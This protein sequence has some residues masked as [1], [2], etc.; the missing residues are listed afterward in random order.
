MPVVLL[1]LFLYDDRENGGTVKKDRMKKGIYQL[2][3]PKLKA[4]N[5]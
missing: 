3:S 2:K 1:L 4:I 5:K